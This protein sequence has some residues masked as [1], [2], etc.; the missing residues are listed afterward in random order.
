MAETVCKTTTWT[1]DGLGRTVAITDPL[2]HSDTFHH[3]FSGE[4]L[5]KIDRD[6]RAT[7][8][9]YDN[10]GRKT[11]EYWYA[12]ANNAAND[13]NRTAALNTFSYSYN[14]NNQ[15]LSV[16]GDVHERYVYDG[17]NLVLVLD[18]G[19][20]M[21]QQTLCG[22][23]VDQVLATESPLSEGDG[24]GGS[25][26]DV[27]W[28]LADNQGSVRDVAV[29]DAAL[30]QTS[31]TDHLVFDGFGRIAAQSNPSA[32]PRFA[33]TAM[34]YDADA[35]LYYDRARWYD[36]AAGRFLSEDPNGFSAGDVNLA[37]YVGNNT[38][39]RI[40]PSGMA[41]M[42]LAQPVY[43]QQAGTGGSP[44]TGSAGIGPLIATA[45]VANHQSGTQGAGN[46][47]VG[48][49]I[50]E[51]LGDPTNPTGGPQLGQDGQGHGFPGQ[52]GRGNTW[53]ADDF[54]V[55]GVAKDTEDD[56][57]GG[58]GDPPSRAFVAK[59]DKDGWGASLSNYWY[60]M[61]N[62]SKMDT[63]LKYGE[64]C[65]WGTAVVAGTAAGG[66]LAWGAFGGAA[67]AGGTGAAGIV[68]I[69][70]PEG[71][72][73][74]AEG[75]VLLGEA[76][77]VLQ[78]LVCAGPPQWQQTVVVMT[79][80][81]GPMIAAGGGQDLIAEQQLVAQA[82]DVLVASW[83]GAHAELTG[84]AYAG[85]NALTPTG[86]VLS[87]GMCENCQSVFNDFLAGTPLILQVSEDGKVFQIVPGGFQ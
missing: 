5:E 36:P 34:R 28:L 86:G 84:L 33:Y 40:D 21:I 23:A 50:A 44:G 29:W 60:Y 68:A 67:A 24:Q 53:D 18:S 47:G 25:A 38:P 48:P 62:P 22:N 42:G 61:A 10:L 15:L 9:A 63:A 79:T 1:F 75:E 19:G 4:L 39:S 74:A 82:N 8:F 70:S 16:G 57:G 87:N 54:A 45:G 73:V 78:E 65:A 85:E 52:N 3:D 11:H 55:R 58:P 7:E 49:L 81:E 77:Q 76:Q 32:Q 6:G 43:F 51:R 13:P 71:Q 80:Q 26:T 59:I 56:D 72:A 17:D 46:P 14:A 12:S 41:A 64:Y 69:E 66:I 20:N 37:R 35:G 2:G 83:P 27:D 31:V 30:G